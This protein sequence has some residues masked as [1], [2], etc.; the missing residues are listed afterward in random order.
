[1]CSLNLSISGCSKAKSP[2]CP[3]LEASSN[4]FPPAVPAVEEAPAATALKT[5]A[6]K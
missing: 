1:M 5:V 3:P 6:E 2:F 4:N